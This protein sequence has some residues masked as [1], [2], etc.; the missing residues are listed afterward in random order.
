MKKFKIG[1]G[2]SAASVIAVLDRWLQTGGIHPNARIGGK[3]IAQ[4][5]HE[6]LSRRFGAQ[7]FRIFRGCLDVLEQGQWRQL[8]HRDDIYTFMYGKEMVVKVGEVPD[9]AEKGVKIQ[10]GVMEAE[11]KAGKDG[12]LGTKDDTVKIRPSNKIL[13]ESKGEDKVVDY[14]ELE[15]GAGFECSECG[16]TY[17][18]SKTVPLSRAEK[19]MVGHIKKDH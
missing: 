11:V 1:S 3:P 15:D 9:K 17:R 8:V 10:V 12:K 16:K 19:L 14:Y 4:V 5:L 6:R 13:K 2:F 18:P 7:R